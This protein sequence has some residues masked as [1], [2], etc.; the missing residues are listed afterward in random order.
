MDKPED[1]DTGGAEE[2]D[3]EADREDTQLGREEN[4]YARSV[5]TELLTSQ[6]NLAMQ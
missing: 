2:E 6:G 1:E 3:M 4:V 5:G